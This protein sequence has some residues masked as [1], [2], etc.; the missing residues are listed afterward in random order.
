MKKILSIYILLLS[1]ISA[2]GQDFEGKLVALDK[3]PIIG[4]M[5]LWQGSD[6][7]VYLEMTV[8]SHYLVYGPRVH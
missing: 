3:E 4:A 6:V 5:V 7:A 1:F 2:F 8:G